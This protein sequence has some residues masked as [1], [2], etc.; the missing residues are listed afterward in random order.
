MQDSSSNSNSIDYEETITHEDDVSPDQ[1]KNKVTAFEDDSY[2]DVEERKRR[3]RERL[4]LKKWVWHDDSDDNYKHKK[5][6]RSPEDL[7]NHRKLGRMEFEDAK[8]GLTAAS[9]KHGSFIGDFTC[10]CSS[11]PYTFRT[12]AI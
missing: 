4:I 3:H 12:L 11:S 5:V 10:S 2:T 9:S 1:D 8:G 6:E 7:E